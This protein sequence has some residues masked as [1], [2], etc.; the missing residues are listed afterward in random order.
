MLITPCPQC[1]EPV[2]L[3]GAVLEQLDRGDDFSVECPWCLTSLTANQIRAQLPPPVR[4]TSNEPLATVAT[5]SSDGSQYGLSEINDGFANASMTETTVESLDDPTFES[6]LQPATE[7]TDDLSGDLTNTPPATNAAPAVLMDV[8]AR[9]GRR[10]RKKKRSPVK[11]VLGMVAGLPLSLALIGVIQWVSGK[12]ILDLGFWPFDGSTTRQA[13][14]VAAPSPTTF[15]QRSSQPTPKGRS[16]GKDL[17]DSDLGEDPAD[18]VANALKDDATD[19]DALPEISFDPNADY[20][21]IVDLNAEDP[22]KKPP[23]SV[24][25]DTSVLGMED[26]ELNTLNTIDNTELE[27]STAPNDNPPTS[28]PESNVAD[29][30][31]EPMSI[32]T[33]EPAVDDDAFAM[34]DFEVEIAQVNDALDRLSA[35]TDSDV[36]LTQAFDQAAQLAATLSSKDFESNQRAELIDG[37]LGR[38]NRSGLVRRIAVRSAD[39]IALEP[40]ARLSDGLVLVGSISNTGDQITLAGGRAAKLELAQSVQGQPTG[41]QIG[42]GHLR[43]DNSIRL[44]RTQAIR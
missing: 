33:P 5:H 32:T 26:L 31:S 28:P 20:E 43:D 15:S 38:I 6:S 35:N 21:G 16:L 3:P 11:T 1:H 9:S 41:L 40:D 37:M 18:A 14:R 29:S 42:I 19:E 4:V 44:L 17:A 36:Y 25:P 39:W 8:E 24:D 22:R 34:A 23:I 30:N 12:Q 13:V 2:R 7:A 27:D 10:R